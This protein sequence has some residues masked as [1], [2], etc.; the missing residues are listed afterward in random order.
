ML[1]LTNSPRVR[2]ETGSPRMSVGSH[3]FR[4]CLIQ[5][6]WVTNWRFQCWIL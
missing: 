2:L 3:R 5:S 1:F 6:L 4:R